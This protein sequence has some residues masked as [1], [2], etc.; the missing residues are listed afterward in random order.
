MRKLTG[1]VAAAGLAA[2]FVAAPSAQALSEGLGFTADDLP[3]W[4][5]NG[6]V[7]AIQA[8]GNVVFAGGTFSQVSPPNGTNG[9]PL[10]VDGLVS[11]NASTGAPAS[12]QPTVALT[13]GTPT[14]KALELA[15]DGKTLYIGG[16]FSNINGVTVGRLAALDVPTCTVKTAFRPSAISNQVWAISATASTVYFGGDF[17]TVAG[18]DR[19]RFAAVDAT[20]GAL[21]PWTLNADDTGRA[22]E[23]GQDGSVMVG[24]VFFT[25][26]GADSHSIAVVDG[27]TGDVIQ[28]Y[29]RGFIPDTSVTHV[30]TSD[31]TGYYVGNEGTGGGVFD[32]TFAID[33]STYAQRWRDLCL[34]ATQALII[35]NGTLYQANHHHDCGANNRGEFT[36]GIR[37]YLTANRTDTDTMLAWRPQLNDGIGEHIG[38]RALTIAQ[39]GSTRYLWVGG[40]FTLVNG[41]SQQGLT[42]FASGPDTGAPATPGPISTQ[43]LQ[44]G[45]IQVSWRASYDDDD[46]LLTYTVYRNGTAV[47]TLQAQS[48]WWWRPQVSW[49][50]TTAVPGTKYLY[51]VRAS[52]GTN[53]SGYSAGVSATVPST[54]A[55]YANAVLNDGATLYWRYDEASG[56]YGADA[57][58]ANMAPQ[59]MKGLTYRDTSNAAL[60]DPG[61]AMAFDGSTGYA[62]SGDMAWAPTTYA[63][64]TWFKTTTTSGGKIVGY[65]SGQPNTGS[66]ST[67]LSSNYDRQVYMTNSGQLIFGVYTGSPQTITSSKS[68]NDGQWH[69]VVATQ[70]SAGMVLY[71]DGLRVGK[72]VTT[73][74]QTYFGAW[75][76]GGDNLSGWPSKPSSN[77][78][79]GDI[80]ETAIY[81]TVLTLA[82]V[83]NHYTLS[84]RTVQGATAPADAYGQAVYSLS[85]DLYW[86]LNETSGTTAVDAG[87]FGD[88]G[89]YFGNV[90]LGVTSGVQATDGVAA[91]FSPTTSSGG[92]ASTVSA[93]N[94]TVYSLEAWFNTGTTTGGK[95]I[96]F[97]NQQTSLSSN[98]DRHVYM[99]DNGQ[100]VFGVWTG[101]ENVITSTSSYNDTQWHHV[102]ATQ[103]PSGMAL[104]VDGVL[105][106][107]NPQTGAQ[108]YTGYWKVGGDRTWEGSRSSYFT[109]LIDEVAVYSDVLTS[110]QVL[111]HY[112]LGAGKPLPDAQAPTA[113]TSLIATPDGESAVDLAW[114]GATDNI[115]VTG[116]AVYRSTTASFTP[117]AA[118]LL[119]TVTGTSYTDSSVTPG[120][121][122]YEVVALDAA[123][124][125]SDPSPAA[126]VTVTGPDVTAPSAPGSL[127][128]TVNDSDVSLTW[129]A[130]TDDRG[131]T[132]YA[133]YRGTSSSG[134]PGSGTLL[135][136]VTRTSYT[137]TSLDPGTYYYTVVALDAANNASDPATPASA[138]ILGPDTSA[139]SV[140]SGVGVSLSGSSAVVTWSASTDDRGVAGYRVFRGTS[141]GFTA[142]SGSQVAQVVGTSYTDASLAAGTYY[143]KVVAFDAAGNV[144]DVSAEVSLTVPEPPAAPVMV[145]LNPTEDSMVYKSNPTTNYGTNTQLAASGSTAS[146]VESFLKFTLPSAPAGTVL[147]SVVLKVRTSTDSMAGSVNSFPV[148]VLSGASW[149]EGTVTWNN[150]P[151]GDGVGFGVLSGA[152][153]TNT[154]YQLTGD[155]SVLSDALGGELTLRIAGNSGDTDNLRLWSQNAATTSYRPTLTL[156]FTPGTTTPD[157]SAPSVPSGV[158]VSLSGSSAVVT[159]SASTDD[160]G[161]AGYRVFRG[162]SAGFTAD[163]GSQVA[164]VVGTSYTDASL[165]AGTYYYK[166]VAFDAA[167]NVSDVSAE[168]SLTVPEPPAAPVMVTLN[169]TEDSMVY[170]SNPTTNYGT[171]T[172][173]AASGSTASPVESFLKFTLPS[174]PA[175]TVLSSVVLKVRT[176]TDSMAGSVNSFP[177]TVLSGA[178]WSEGTV[179][180]NNRPAG[181]GVGFGVL[182]GATATNT[183]YQLTGDASVLSD[184]LGGELTLRI[185]GN[186][187][188]TDNLRLWSQNAA[189]TSYRPT[190]TLT[191]TPE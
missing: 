150:R 28:A 130:A 59:F 49:V 11:L 161:V 118:T 25:V 53:V 136:T 172:Q 34:G 176:S 152:T 95:I 117:S 19:E 137:D 52:D 4:Q 29:P 22:V 147:S 138:T 10:G 111:L 135:A 92:L 119:T 101:S 97:G 43:T 158:G 41:K 42:R 112:D 78:F 88:N 94:P 159:W 6:E 102:V 18:Q 89:T 13:G 108:S 73:N 56:R 175:G 32:G 113:P 156:T 105:V 39:N 180:W 93:S 54:S 86:R 69:Y 64:E 48:R 61:Y 98:Y 27:T 148:T 76:V 114:S 40:E 74:A 5:A 129:A 47:A 134:L 91:S 63:I 163:S 187:G 188:D 21:L 191:F 167:G 115:G 131:V 151:A 107:T 165:A 154:A 84:G 38:P 96:G 31:A 67:I 82:Q 44:S 72:N 123:N 179:T 90:R 127:Q 183:A 109:G 145:T 16:N 182:S 121:Y 87:P 51:Q 133:V 184:A 157:T 70:G 170:K 17:T 45:K 57:S 166:V 122:Y 83:Q 125:A 81:P 162:T 55:P 66:G 153:A 50:D 116:Y 126:S 2:M 141:A 120:T 60:N 99:K 58:T 104:Y 36:D 169:P 177:V 1:F 8:V 77:F 181:D 80:D 20:T 12:C 144:S 37:V 132:G 185:A 15:P 171:N 9:T 142:D 149:S 124:N 3:T 106:G 71:V 178:S 173:L 143:Y 14:I 30:I 168:V 189:T 146:P 24:G 26:N 140:P 68:Y 155:A 79:A 65:G 103:G 33:Y 23:A 190:L 160:R 174:A 110:A 7:W 46:G 128:A 35:D 186:S 100:L 139:P 75:H 164:Q 85:P 62:Y